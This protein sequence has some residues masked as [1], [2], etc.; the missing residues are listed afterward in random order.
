MRKVFSGIIPNEENEDE[1]GGLVE[2]DVPTQ[3]SGS[4]TWK[5]PS[6]SSFS[7]MKE[8]KKET[9]KCRRGDLPFKAL[10]VKV[11]VLSSKNAFLILI[12]FNEGDEDDE[13][14]FGE[15]RSKPVKRM[16]MRKAFF[17]IIDPGQ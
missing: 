16:R 7:S 6:S 10:P 11:R 13:G 1:E 3:L 2:V 14:V 4:I 17:R 9:R 8:M 15:Y 5:T 12:F